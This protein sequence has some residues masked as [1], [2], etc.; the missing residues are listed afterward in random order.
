[1]SFTDFDLKTKLIDRFLSATLIGKLYQRVLSA[2]YISANVSSFPSFHRRD[3]QERDSIL[4]AVEREKR[5]GRGRGK[6]GRMEG[7][8]AVR[9]GRG[10]GRGS[11]GG[12]RGEA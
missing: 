6:G 12:E 5:R 7:G 4:F 9:E 2:S 8:G 3:K 1:M 11:E 10:G